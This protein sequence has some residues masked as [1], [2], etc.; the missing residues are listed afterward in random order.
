M[1][2][3]RIAEAWQNDR[4]KIL[5]TS[6][7]IMEQLRAQAET[8]ATGADRVD[9]T[10]LDSAFN[11]FRRTFDSKLGGFGSGAEVSAAFGSQLPAAL[12]EAHRA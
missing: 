3:E 4:E 1:I 12:L 2:L 5:S 10:V 9:A 11:Q 6:A 8:S 7:G